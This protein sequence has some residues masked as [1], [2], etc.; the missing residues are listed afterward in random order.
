MICRRLHIA[1]S[2]ALLV[3]MLLMLLGAVP[4]AVAQHAL[5]LDPA[6]ALSQYHTDTWTIDDGLPQESATGGTQGLDCHGRSFRATSC[7]RFRS[8]ERL[9]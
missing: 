5:T 7:R 8:D 3:G 2:A 1:R 9:R 4:G 6:K